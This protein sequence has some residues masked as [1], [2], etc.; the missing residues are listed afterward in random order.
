MTQFRFTNHCAGSFCVVSFTFF[1]GY[2]SSFDVIS[3]SGQRSH[4]N[5]NIVREY[6]VSLTEFCNVFYGIFIAFIALMVRD[7]HCDDLI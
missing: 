3:S 1:N 5:L 2:V 4:F 7:D 6:A